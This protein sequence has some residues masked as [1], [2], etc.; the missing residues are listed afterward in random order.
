MKLLKYTATIF[1]LVLFGLLLLNVSCLNVAKKFMTEDANETKLSTG[2]KAPGF[3]LHDTTGRKVSLSNFHGKIVVL[4]WTSTE[5]PFV[6]DHYKRSAMRSIFDKYTKRDVV[7]LAIDSSH[8]TNK[9]NLTKWIRKNAIEY[10]ILMDPSGQIGKAYGAK[11]T[12]HMFIIGKNG[13]IAYQGAL[14][15]GY[16]GNGKDFV[17]PALDSLL[18]SEE[19]DVPK[20]GAFGCYIKYKD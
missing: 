16:G 14:D 2:E 15:D 10:P 9:E 17:S 7:W 3:I 5:C 19:V 6:K 20:T 12:P 8:D 1:V 13:T 4:E 18:K 11:R